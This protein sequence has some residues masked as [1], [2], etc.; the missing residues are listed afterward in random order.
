M[1]Q[2]WVTGNVSSIDSRRILR[3]GASQG[4]KHY[5]EADNIVT[6]CFA[7]QRGSAIIFPLVID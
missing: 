1:D 4:A 7:H 2:V 3:E 5:G 6:S